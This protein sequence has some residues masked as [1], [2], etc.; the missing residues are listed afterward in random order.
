[1]KVLVLLILYLLSWPLTFLYS[2]EECLLRLSINIIIRNDFRGEREFAERIKAACKNLQ[3]NAEIYDLSALENSDRVCDWSLTLV[4]GKAC[5]SKQNDYLILFEP[6]HHYFTSDGH[7]HQNYLDYAGYLT[8]YKNT[9]LL[10]E[11]IAYEPERFYCKRWYPTVQ[12]RPYKQVAPQYLFYFLGLWGDR[13]E[14]SRYLTLQSKLAQK[15]YTAFFGSPIIG[16]PYGNAFRGAID[17]NGEAV[18]DLISEMGVCLVLHSKTHLHYGIPSGRIFE[19]AAAS[20][21]ILSDLN[22]FVIEHFGDSV[23]YVDQELSGEEMF[24]Q[25]DAHMT[26]IQNHPEKALEMARKAHK[27]FEEKFLLE[28]QL[29]DFDQ[30]HRSRRSTWQALLN[31]KDSD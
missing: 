21:V 14:N 12:Y 10:L 7:L 4:P 5:C 15:N 23:F 17:Y 29:L 3:W 6:T 18:L 13:Y 22:P 8:T 16:A 24:E 11:D 28:D 19:A 25:I 20:A 27:I 26:W 1:M 9:E 2:K 30:F 31:F